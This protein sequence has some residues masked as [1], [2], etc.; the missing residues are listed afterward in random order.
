[1]D[2]FRSFVARNGF[3]PH[4]YCFTWD[5]ALLWSMVG[6]DAVIA[7]SYLSI[8]VAILVY[9]KKRSD[10][11]WGYLPWLFSAFI[12]SC[13]VTHVMDLWTIWSPDYR[14]MPRPRS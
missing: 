6:A 7:I 14:T 1:M 4:G 8:P 2:S 12:F 5:P 9:V 3:L 10:V 13:G 11:E